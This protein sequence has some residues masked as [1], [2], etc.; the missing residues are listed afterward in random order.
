MRPPVRA[1]S[2]LCSTTA[3][4]DWRLIVVL[5]I[6]MVLMIVMVMRI[7]GGRRFGVRRV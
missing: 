6:A 7:V 2:L 1:G 3:T 5:M 4:S